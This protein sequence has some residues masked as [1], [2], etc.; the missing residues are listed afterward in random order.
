MERGLETN[1]VSWQGRPDVTLNS[2]AT[3]A[4]EVLAHQRL[5]W[6]PLVALQPRPSKQGLGHP[7]TLRN[8][9]NRPQPHS[10]HNLGRKLVQHV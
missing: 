10:R 4:R 2:W 3:Q 9:H 6:S 5:P 7:A 1:L 8:Q